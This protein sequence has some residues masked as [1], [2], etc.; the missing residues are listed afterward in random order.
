LTLYAYT[1]GL[2]VTL[3]SIHMYFSLAQSTYPSKTKN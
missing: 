1:N 3:L 2:A